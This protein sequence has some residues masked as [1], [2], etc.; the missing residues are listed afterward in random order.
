[1]QGS[2]HS[3]VS[4]PNAMDSKTREAALAQQSKDVKVKDRSVFFFLNSRGSMTL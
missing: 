3:S 2:V 4:A 1:M